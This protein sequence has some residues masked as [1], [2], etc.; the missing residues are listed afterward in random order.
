M[1]FGVPKRHE[2][3]YGGYI[4]LDATQA[5]RDVENALRDFIAH[6]LEKAF[7]V[8]WEK[9]CGVSTERHERWHE[10]QKTEA[11]RQKTGVIEERLLYYADFYDLKPILKKHWSQHFSMVFVSGKQW[12][13][14]SASWKNSAIQTL[15]DVNYFHTNNILP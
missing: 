10:R 15:I 8:E 6:T 7:G 9:Q 4:S 5:L 3:M 12:M 2:E 14:G 11:Q 13:F 1:G